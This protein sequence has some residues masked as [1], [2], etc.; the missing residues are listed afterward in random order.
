MK[1]LAKTL[2]AA[3]VVTTALITTE[4][5]SPGL[6]V[7]PP[8]P[9][10]S[11]PPPSFP[12]GGQGGL[13]GAGTG[14]C[15]LLEVARTAQQQMWGLQLRPALPALR[16]MLFPFAPAQPVKF[17]MHRTPAPLDMVFVRSGQVI[18]V[19]ANVP[20]C[21]HLPCR[22]YGPD[23]A[24]DGVIELGAGQSQVLG[25]KTGRAVLIRPATAPRG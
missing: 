21:M 3:A 13:C 7:P 12:P 19:E 15:I 20:P 11:P 18:A 9:P 25:I 8:K 16:G 10:P 24:V 5:K 14:P 17:W 2:A 6:A 4:L 22:S 1:T 23:A